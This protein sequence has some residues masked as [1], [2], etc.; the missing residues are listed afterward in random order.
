MQDSINVNYQLTQVSEVAG[1]SVSLVIDRSGSMSTEMMNDAKNAA[2]QYVRTMGPLDRSAIITFS[3]YAE[4]AQ[5]ITSDTS[6][7]I[8]AINKIV[9]YDMTALLDGTLEGLKQ[10]SNETNTRA[11]I[12]FSDGLENYS[13]V[14]QPEVIKYARDNNITIYSIGIGP[15]ADRRVLQALADSTGGYFTTAP[16]AAQLAQIYAQIKSD[17]QSQYIL[18]YRSPDQVFNGDTHQVVVSVNLNSHT[19]RDTVYW[20]E[21]NQPP[22]ISLTTETQAMLTTSQQQNQPLT[23][24]ANVTDDGAISSVRLFYRPSNLSSGA[25]TEVPMLISSGSVYQVTIPAASV[26]YPG[27][28]FYILATDNY[29]L[30]GRSPNILAPETDPWV[31]PVGNN[32]PTISDL[33][34]VCLTPGTNN[35]IS[36]KIDDDGGIHL[37]LLY[38]KKRNETFF[39]IDTMTEISGRYTGTIPQIM[40]TSNGIDYYIRAVANAGAAARYPSSGY[41]SLFLCSGN[42]TITAPANASLSEGETLNLTASA[43]N[44]DGTTPLISAI[45]PPAWLSISANSDNTYSITLAPGCNDSGDYQIHLIATNSIDTAHAYFN[46]RVNDVNFPPVF[47]SLPFEQKINE[48]VPY[49]LTVRVQ[50]CDGEIPTIRMLTSVAG[51]TF[52]DNHNSTGTFSWT[53]DADDYG[54]YLYIFEATDGVNDPVRDTI[55]IEVIDKNVAPPVL[56][57]STVDTTIS[58]NLPIVIVAHATDADGTVPVLK[59]IQLPGSAKFTTDNNGNAV[60]SWTPG[61]TGTFTFKIIAFDRAD[62]LSFD[63]QT[64]TIRVNNENITGPEFEPHAD[65]TIQQ[66]ENL[67]LNLRATDPDGTIP[68]LRLLDAP[69]GSHLIDNGNGTAI[70]SWSPA[71]DISGTFLFKAIATDGTFYD[72]IEIPVHVRDVNCTPVFFQTEDVNAIPGER[73]RAYDPDN[74]GSIPT[75]SV[76]STLPDYSFVTQDNGSAVFNWTVSYTGGSY[77]VTFYATDGNSTDSMKITV[78]INKTGSLKIIARPDSCRI[79]AF[80]SDCYKGKLI[81]VGSTV[82]SGAPGTC[83]FEFQAPGYRSQRVACNIRPDTTT[84][85]SIDLKPAI[86]LMV[87]SPDTLKCGSSNLITDN[88]SISFADLN[89]DRIPDL[90]IATA[91]GIICYYGID[92]TDN[93]LFSPIADTFF[94]GTLE[95]SLHHTFIHWNNNVNLSCILSTRTGKILRINLQNA[96]MDTLVSISSSRLYPT[97][98]DANGDGRKDLIVVNAGKGLFVYFNTGSDSVPAI[99]FAKECTTPDGLSL[100]GLN[101]AA[102][103]LDTDMDGKEEVIAFSEGKLKLFKPDSTFSTLTYIENLSCGGKLVTADSMSFSLI[104]STRGVSSFAIRNGNHILVYPTHLQGDVTFDG[105]VDIHDISTASRNWEMTPDDQAWDPSINVKLSEDG[106][107]K[108]DI[109]DVSR[110]S[111]SWELQQ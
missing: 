107:E 2:L 31:I 69:S 65:V 16:S 109:R 76:Y 74:N 84:T 77:P 85:L 24:T 96:T 51:A 92:S 5:A 43:S 26:I 64:V 14:G 28:D 71:C 90:S 50:D 15:S 78:S 36:A 73:V 66:N 4:I 62:S 39:A 60:F 8:S 70:V 7:L 11:V 110:I 93:S 72:T 21:S 25:Y 13:H 111:K 35:S 46:V 40:V 22:V 44:P 10:L 59:G 102:L 56:T 81:G 42:L 38:Y 29:N 54:Y 104:G 12:V 37:A 19:D 17:I 83:W 89:R 27:I 75:L 9:T 105:K 45:T 98:F 53:P 91:A 101:G 82:Y 63:S 97:I 61:D 20:D 86:P 34:T 47:D 108:I 99:A 1:I 94:S 32:V 100:T 87:L 95:P 49:E 57:V 80:P 30:I 6:S 3:D 67:V 48:A 58:V 106:I 79:Y 52:T 41:D 18:C 23:I 55:I 103:L 68:T 33:Q 88:G